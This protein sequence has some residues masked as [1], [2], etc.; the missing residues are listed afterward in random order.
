MASGWRQAGGR[1]DEDPGPR[2]STS[3]ALVD[4]SVQEDGRTLRVCQSAFGAWGN[5]HVVALT[6]WLYFTAPAG[7]NQICSNPNGYRKS[8]ALPAPDAQERVS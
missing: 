4:L 2:L 6:R 3:L 1:E 7:G 8:P 5:P